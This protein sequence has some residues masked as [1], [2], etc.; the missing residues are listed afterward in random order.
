MRSTVM[1]ALSALGAFACG[2]GD[3]AGRAAASVVEV[4]MTGDPRRGTAT[5]EPAAITIAPG[6]TVR[7]LNVA[8]FP[9]TVAFWADSIP[10]GSAAML[11]SALGRDRVDHLHGP[12]LT[13]PTESFDIAFAVDAPHGIYRGYCVPHLALGMALAITVR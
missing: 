7:F 13:R 6:T 4:L 1:T 12:Y 11:D 2:G 10:L 3:A 8:G 5:F 9:H